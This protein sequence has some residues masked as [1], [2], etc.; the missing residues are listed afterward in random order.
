MEPPN[1]RCVFFF[2]AEWHGAVRRQVACER[3][4]GGGNIRES[5]CSERSPAGDA[6]LREGEKHGHGIGW[7]EFEDMKFRVGPK[8]SR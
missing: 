3:A 1:S 6:T 2:L 8:K 4:F 5:R 7:A